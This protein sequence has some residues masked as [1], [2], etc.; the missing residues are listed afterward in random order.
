MHEL[1]ARDQ[2]L[3]TQRRRDGRQGQWLP[4]AA[5][6]AALGPAQRTDDA[7]GPY[8]ALVATGRDPLEHLSSTTQARWRAAGGRT[9]RLPDLRPALGDRADRWCYLVRPDRV[10]L[11]EDPLSGAQSLVH[12]GLALLGGT[13]RQPSAE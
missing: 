12:E 1:N 5:L 10:V 4:Q 3:F 11:H 13:E 8:M 2:G 6:S 9:A 7:L